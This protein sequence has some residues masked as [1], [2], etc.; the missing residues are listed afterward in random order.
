M[1]AHLRVTPLTE[2]VSTYL[3]EHMPEAPYAL[4]AKGEVLGPFDIKL[5]YHLDRGWEAISAEEIG[6]VAPTRDLVV[7]ARPTVPDGFKLVLDKEQRVQSHWQWWHPLSKQWWAVSELETAR[8]VEDILVDWGMRS[9]K[10]WVASPVDPEDPRFVELPDNCRAVMPG[11]KLRRG[12]L[13]ID[14]SINAWTEISHTA[15]GI[16]VGAPEHLPGFTRWCRPIGDDWQA[17]FVD[18]K[19]DV[20]GKACMA[21]GA[22]NDP[23]PDLETAHNLLQ[24]RGKA[25]KKPAA[26]V[27]WDIRTFEPL[28]IYDIEE[29]AYAASRLQAQRAR[30]APPERDCVIVGGLTDMAQARGTTPGDIL[31]MAMQ[32]LPAGY[33]LLEHTQQAVEVVAKGDLE[34]GPFDDNYRDLTWQPVDTGHIGMRV[35]L[36]DLVF[37]RDMSRVVE[38]EIYEEIDQPA[39]AK[40]IK[41]VDT[42]DKALKEAKTAIRKLQK[43]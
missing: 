20:K 36:A 38:E 35:R 9:H 43:E 25:T 24:H 42:M 14:D 23:F 34:Y 39:L 22:K 5:I 8:C 3:A 18:T 17:W 13:Y 10:T 30:V 21:T 26:G 27:V 11:E 37:A 28:A 40:L 19:R 12:D 32:S 4:L 2:K 6:D 29:P 33:A 31:E 1:P 15:K 41:A 16:P 7:F